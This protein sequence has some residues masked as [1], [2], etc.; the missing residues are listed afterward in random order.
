[1]IAITRQQAEKLF[2][3]ARE[4]S[5]KIEQKSGQIKI[6]IALDNDQSLFVVYDHENHQESFF[7]KGN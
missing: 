3:Q 1:M 4:K 5:H 6:C 7:L 2:D